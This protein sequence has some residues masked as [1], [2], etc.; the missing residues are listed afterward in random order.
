GG[1][2]GAAAVGTG[3]KTTQKGEVSA[4]NTKPAS[5]RGHSSYEAIDGSDVLGWRTMFVGAGEDVVGRRDNCTWCDRLAL[6]YHA[7]MHSSHTES[8]ACLGADW[9]STFAIVDSWS[10]FKGSAGNRYYG[11]I[12]SSIWDPRETVALASPRRAERNTATS[13][14]VKL[15]GWARTGSA[16]GRRTGRGCV[17]CLGRVAAPSGWARSVSL[18]AGT[19]RF[20]SLGSEAHDA[21]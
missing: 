11:V 10:P 16:E 9:A 7:A 21:G 3:A 6:N 17:G 19:A 15:I 13:L 5:E 18:W 8:H 20:R 1:C 14:D 12:S 4:W 2:R